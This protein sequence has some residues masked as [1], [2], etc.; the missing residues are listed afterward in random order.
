V[1]RPGRFGNKEFGKEFGGKG[2]DALSDKAIG[3]FIKGI[4]PRRI[5]G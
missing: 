1:T 5:S 3:E 4:K 2:I